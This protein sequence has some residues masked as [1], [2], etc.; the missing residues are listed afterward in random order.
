LALF[1]HLSYGGK[2]YKKEGKCER[3]NKE[4]IKVKKVNKCKRG[5]KGLGV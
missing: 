4:K 3:R 2:K 5:K 1:F